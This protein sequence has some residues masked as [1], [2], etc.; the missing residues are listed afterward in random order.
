MGHFLRIDIA[1]NAMDTADT[2]H[3]VSR[4]DKR[5]AVGGVHLHVAHIA[6]DCVQVRTN[7]FI[8]RRNIFGFDA[9]HI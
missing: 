6:F 8:Y 7:V 3:N 4:P 1:L 9:R 5:V 2:G